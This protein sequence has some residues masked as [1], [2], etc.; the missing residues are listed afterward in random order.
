MG[1]PSAPIKSQTIKLTSKCSHAPRSDGQ[2]PLRTAETNVFN[3]NMLP[4]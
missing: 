4:R 2:C 1:T 3:E